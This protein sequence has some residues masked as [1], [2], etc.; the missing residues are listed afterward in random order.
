MDRLVY[1]RYH[2]SS[3]SAALKS[4]CY[5]RAS[6]MKKLAL[7][8]RRYLCLISSRRSDFSNGSPRLPSEMRSASFS[9]GC[10]ITKS[11]STR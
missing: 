2:C 4:T 8:D 7:V 10:V 3:S 9:A 1:N 6:A 11:C 5:S